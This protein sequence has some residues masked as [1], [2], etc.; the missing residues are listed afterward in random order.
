MHYELR[1]WCREWGRNPALRGH[2]EGAGTP[3]G[4]FRCVHTTLP[5]APG[6]AGR[7]EVKLGSWPGKLRERS[8]VPGVGSAFLAARREASLQ[9]EQRNKRVLDAL[10]TKRLVYFKFSQKQTKGG[11][12]PGIINV[13]AGPGTTRRNLTD[14]EGLPGLQFKSHQDRERPPP[15]E[16][17]H[18]LSD[19]ASFCRPLAGE[20]LCFPEEPLPGCVRPGFPE[21]GCRGWQRV[22]AGPPS[23]RGQRPS[24][25]ARSSPQDG[26][27]RG[28]VFA[29]PPTW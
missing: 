20:P 9:K 25:L 27:Q 18:T 2:P 17:L 6:A 19:A 5:R 4:C 12:S 15:R 11:R 22:A 13:R 16:Q 29:T 23:A 8:L 3:P 28:G 10:L 26:G 7:P 14:P 21:R 1:A 24:H